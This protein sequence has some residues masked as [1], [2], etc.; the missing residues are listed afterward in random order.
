MTTP[1][2]NAIATV[3]YATVVKAWKQV[4][5]DTPFP[6]LPDSTIRSWLRLYPAVVVVASIGAAS[7]A[8]RPFADE[9]HLRNYIFKTLPRMATNYRDLQ[10]ARELLAETLS[11]RAC[12][13]EPKKILIT[14]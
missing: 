3:D 8:P 6:P 4:T 7:H 10:T 5:A 1:P 11:E 12:K 2:G 13:K 14:G 9:T